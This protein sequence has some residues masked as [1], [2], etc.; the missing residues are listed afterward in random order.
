MSVFEDHFGPELESENGKL[1]PT[2]NLIGSAE[3]IGLYFSAHWC[4]PCRSF[5]PI[6]AES[7]RTLKAAGKP[8]EIV[9]VSS[10]RD[11]KSFQEYANEMPWLRLPFA[12]RDRKEKLSAKY[13][14]QGIPTLIL[15]GKDGK[16]LSSNGRSVITEDPSGQNFPW[17]PPT[18]AD[19]MGNEFEHNDHTKLTT[20]D[21]KGKVVGLYFSAH[22]CPPCKGF[23]P[24]LADVYKKVQVLHPNKFEVI[25]VSSDRDEAQFHEYHHSMPW[26]ALPYAD[27]AR[28]EKLSKLFD[29][30]GIPSFVILDFDTGT[31]INANGRGSISGDLEGARFPWYPLPV[32]SLDSPEGINETRSVV[33]FASAVDKAAQD[34]IEAELTKVSIRVREEAKAKGTDPGLL[35]FLS[36]S[37]GGVSARI[38]ELTKIKATTVTTIVLDIPNDGAFYVDGDG[39]GQVTA[40]GIEAL[41]EKVDKKEIPQKQLGQ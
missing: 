12:D 4:G 20:A 1:H 18:L 40:A 32:S 21:L 33:V 35:F 29:I 17:L 14:V 27:R 13:K 9:F 6:L 8:F 39:S 36:R 25:F 7:Y 34:N 41:L 15:L 10:D 28:K 11:D 24:V 31:I 30:E 2:A 19:A 26:P 23:T 38:Q 37:D 3:V 16:L 5:T 22:W